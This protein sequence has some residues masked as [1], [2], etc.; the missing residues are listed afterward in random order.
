METVVLLPAIGLVFV[1]LCLLV[2]GFA[3]SR[4]STSGV[5]ALMV[6]GFLVFCSIF[7]TRS[8]YMEMEQGAV[9]YAASDSAV[10]ETHSVSPRPASSGRASRPGRVRVG[11]AP[12]EPMDAGSTSDVS[13][14]TLERD[15]TFDVEAPRVDPSRGESE[16]RHGDRSAPNRSP[17]RLTT[18]FV[19]WDV[20]AQD[21]WAEWVHAGKTHVFQSTN[22][23]GEPPAWVTDAGGSKL[24]TAQVGRIQARHWAPGP[25]GAL[26]A[27]SE[28]SEPT[29]REAINRAGEALF[30]KV[31]M[32]GLLRWEARRTI[33]VGHDAPSSSPRSR[34]KEI[35]D[36]ISLAAE[37][38]PRALD[39]KP[40]YSVEKAQLTF[41]GVHIYRA[42]AHALPTT[43]DLDRLAGLIDEA[44]ADNWLAA[45]AKHRQTVWTLLGGGFASLII[46]LVFVLANART[47]G[48]FAWPLRLLT[49]ATIIGVGG[50]VASL[51]RM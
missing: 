6:V 43:A 25:D 2:V 5:V 41:G 1:V 32:L 42:A 13:R 21:D 19:V 10:V 28:S 12:E 7:I 15:E 8:N 37:L 14:T 23:A 17:R 36:L 20:E 39:R 9:E 18:N 4:S 48:H 50:L 45:R 11:I 27:Y 44:V 30:R 47:K 24:I 40:R 31:G 38:A 33:T 35:D 16:S 3:F 29:Q 49:L 46:F 22:G 34:Q 51:L 26:V